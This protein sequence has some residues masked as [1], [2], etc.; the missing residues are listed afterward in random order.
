MQRE[1]RR[2]GKEWQHIGKKIK[3][4]RVRHFVDIPWLRDVKS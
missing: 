3:G 2:K 1:R 4:G